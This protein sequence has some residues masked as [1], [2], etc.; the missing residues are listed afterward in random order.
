LNE[1][2][3]QVIKRLRKEKNFTQEELAEQLGVTAQAVS[4][5]ESE[6]GLPDISQVVPLA[7]VFGVPTDVLFGRFGI[8]DNEEVERIITEISEKTGD[9]SNIEELY[10]QHLIAYD[11]Y[12]DALKNYPSNTELLLNSLYEGMN[13]VQD[14]GMDN[15]DEEDLLKYVGEKRVLEILAECERKANLILRYSTDMVE[16]DQ[17]K[18]QLVNIYVK[19][20]QIDRAVDIAENFTY[21][22]QYTKSVRL[23]EI[24]YETKERAMEQKYRCTAIS[25]GLELIEY[26]VLMLGKSYRDEGNYDDALRCFDWIRDV[27]SLTYR[28]DEK[29]TPPFAPFSRIRYTH[30]YPAYCLIKLGRIDEAIDRLEQIYDFIKNNVYDWYRDYPKTPIMAKTE[31]GCA[32]YSDVITAEPSL[33]DAKSNI[34]RFEELLHDNPRYR[35][36]VE[37]VTALTVEE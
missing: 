36:L 11:L 5:W 37:K 34:L 12:A 27:V 17:A 21:S 9:Y 4:K 16:L 1:T 3:G 28:D 10:T 24:Y 32:G 29:F 2:I 13:I 15:A 20:K 33:G 35:A 6:I 8:N 22:S 7:A 26:E 18:R 31:L 14:Y 25:D 30:T 23:A 19:L